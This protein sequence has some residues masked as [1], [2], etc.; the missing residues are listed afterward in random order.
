MRAFVRW[1]YARANSVYY[2]SSNV[3]EVASP[4][5]STVYEFHSLLV[6]LFLFLQKKHFNENK[7]QHQRIEY[8]STMCVCLSFI[9]RAR[10]LIFMSLHSNLMDYFRCLNVYKRQ[11]VWIQLNCKQKATWNIT[12][13]ETFKFP[14]KWMEIGGSLK[15]QN[16]HFNGDYLTQQQGIRT[17]R[18]WV[19]YKLKQ[20][21]RWIKVHQRNLFRHYWQ[22]CTSV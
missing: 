22:R 9:T 14:M 18:K 4:M 6:C 7:Q 16:A 21:M 15:N 11:T 12:D 1:L 20:I 19:I 5:Q 8:A 2:H 3:D 10:E 17:K 13:K